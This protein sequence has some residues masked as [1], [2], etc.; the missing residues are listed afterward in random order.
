MWGCISASICVSY[1]FSLAL[2]L[3]F[4]LFLLFSFVCFYFILFYYYRLD[5]RLFSK[6]IEKVCEFRWKG[7]W[8]RTEG[9]RKRKIRIYC[10]K[11]LLSLFQLLKTGLFILLYYSLK[12]K[13]VMK[14]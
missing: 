4:G 9:S 6:D 8:G 12:K 2:F 5:A 7:R 10:M 11:N 14:R 1:T 13:I 3:L